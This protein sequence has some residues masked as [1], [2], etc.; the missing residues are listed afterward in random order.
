M[1]VIVTDSV[2]A[3]VPRSE[4][5][6]EM[7]DAHMGMMDRLMSQAQRKLSGAIK[8]SN[9]AMISTNQ[10]Q[11]R[12]GAVYGK[13]ETTTRGKGLRFHASVR[14]DVRRIQTAK[15]NGK[16]VRS[17]KRVRVTKNK[18]APPF[19]ETEFDILSDCGPTKAGHLLDLGAEYGIIDEW[20]SFYRHN[21]E[22]VGQ[23]RENAKHSLSE[24]TG[25]ANT[26]EKNI[27]A[28]VNLPAP[29][30]HGHPARGEEAPGE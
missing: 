2:S 29:D 26:I 20:G 8:Q 6:G 19:G 28:E 3:L 27:R 7:G 10:L 21:K 17:R 12:I 18:A 23:G 13:R 1:D 22:L 5:K 15:S 16:A 24:S 25:A 11:E 9:S 30:R 4:I 14:L